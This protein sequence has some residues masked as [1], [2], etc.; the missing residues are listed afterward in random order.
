N[1]DFETGDFTGWSFDESDAAIVLTNPPT[2]QPGGASR[3]LD[4]PFIPCFDPPA[5][6]LNNHYMACLST[7]T[8]F[9]GEAAGGV[10]SDLTSDPI[11]LSFKPD[12][13]T[14]VFSVDFQTEE[15][16]RSLVHNDTFQARFITDQGSFPIFGIDTFG[17]TPVGRGVTIQ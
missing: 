4:A 10:R 8:F 13:F 14:V 16:I 1:G 15:P 5:D 9:G 12:I 7:G 11:E 17:L 6:P 3:A 2:L